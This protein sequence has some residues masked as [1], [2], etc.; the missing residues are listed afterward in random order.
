MRNALLALLGMMSISAYSWTEAET[1]MVGLA[2][3][4][5][6]AY[7]SGCDG[8]P[9]PPGDPMANEPLDEPFPTFG[10]LFE[11]S[12]PCAQDWTPEAKRAAFFHYLGMLP[13]SVT[14]GV[15][16]GDEWYA[17]SA[18][19]FCR[20]KGDV[21]V[22]MPAMGVLAATNMPGRCQ[23]EAAGIVEK[24]AQ[25]TEAMNSCLDGALSREGC[26]N[27]APARRRV[28]DAYS[29]KLGLAYDAGQ[30]N[31]ARNGSAALYHGLSDHVGA[32]SLDVLL[33]RVFPD[34]AVSSN[35][36]WVATHALASDPNEEW[37]S[38]YFTN[39]T[40]LLMNT[41]QPLPVVDGL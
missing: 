36:L 11:A 12:L 23:W 2:L 18:L 39:I 7:A 20:V 14:N 30:T 32:R 9:L 40:N 16:G 19:G 13:T 27:H 31:L 33:L 15:F 25:A 38:G 10:S 22:L 21:A 8:G 35:R 37:T 4:E 34:Y 5:A 29:N 1:N 26:L 24:W 3:A 41:T 28:Y 17:S 6:T